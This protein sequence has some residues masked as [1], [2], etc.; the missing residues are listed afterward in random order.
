MKNK[1]LL[2]ILI[3]IIIIL[4]VIG[5]FI[6]KKIQQN[7]QIEEI[8]EYIPEEEISIEGLRQTIVSLYFN[9][10]DTNMLIPE[11]RSIDVKEL[12]KNPYNVLVNLLIEGP[13]S[14]KLEKVIPDGTKVNKIEIKD[15]I[16][17]LDLSKEFIENHKG[18]AEAESRTVYS[19][20]N[21]LT[22]LN[23]VEAVKIL[24][25]GKEDAAFK[26]N[27]ISFKNPFVKQENIT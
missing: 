4:A 26:D 3:F 1:K 14:E 5:L 27:L 11:A 9:Q 25:D 23:E 18:G 21:T 12:V 2:I 20:V 13:K 24:I 16:I 15:E 7:N 19:I 17:Y 6:I 10:K 8:T 22:Q